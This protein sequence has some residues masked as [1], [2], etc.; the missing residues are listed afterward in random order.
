M[1][2]QLALGNIAT[3]NVAPCQDG[4]WPVEFSVVTPDFVTFVFLSYRIMK[5]GEGRIVHEFVEL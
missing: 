2:I 1:D 3:I 5:D 4:N